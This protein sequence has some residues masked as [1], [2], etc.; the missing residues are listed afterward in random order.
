P[1]PPPSDSTYDYFPFAN[2]TIGQ[3]HMMPG[4]KV[5]DTTGFIQG[6]DGFVNPIEFDRAVNANIAIPAGDSSAYLDFLADSGLVVGI[7]DN[8]NDAGGLALRYTSNKFPNGVNTKTAALRWN[9]GWNGYRRSGKWA[10]YTLAFPEG[11]YQFV[12][13]FRDDNGSSHSLHKLRV[14]VFDVMNTTDTLMDYTID[15]SDDGAGAFNA[16]HMPGDTVDNVIYIGGN[17]SINSGYAKGLPVL[18]IPTAGNYVLRLEELATGQG[19]FSTFTFNTTTDSMPPPPPPTDTLYA[20]FPYAGLSIGNKHMMPGGLISDTTGNDDPALVNPWEFDRAVNADIMIPAGDSTAYLDYLADSAAVFGITDN[21]NDA[22]GGVKRGYVSTKFPNGANAKSAPIRWNNGWNGWRRTGKWAY[23][24]MNFP[25]GNYQFVYRAR[26]DGGTSFSQHG[27]RL[28]LFPVTNVTDTI[29]DITVD[30]SDDGAG[31]LKDLFAPGDTIDNVIYIG[32]GDSTNFGY[33]RFF[34]VVDVITIPTAG[35]YVFRY[36]E[37]I[38]GAGQFANFTFNTEVM[39]DTTGGD[40][41]I[42]IGDMRPENLL[43]MYSYDNKVVITFSERVNA[44]ISIANIHGQ[45]LMSKEFSGAKFEEEV[46]VAD[47][48]YLLMVETADGYAVRKIHLHDQ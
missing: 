7:T 28:T 11:D 14:T 45:L 1:P 2:Q 47:G 19:M 17:D 42:S 29:A 5:V 44:T 9:G 20:Y 27:L 10:H 41:T 21:G 31:S 6:V 43:Q 22:G 25:E 23:Y 18:T 24:T 4:T 12:Y 16:A 15:L 39:A 26:V 33:S 38:P 32:G 46:P 37:T 13:R 36:E 30:L 35:D 34:R 8:G 3:V 48:V 40:T